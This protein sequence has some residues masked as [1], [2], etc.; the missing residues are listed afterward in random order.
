MWETLQFPA[1]DDFGIG[2]F[3]NKEDNKEEYHDTNYLFWN[4]TDIMSRFVKYSNENS[5]QSFEF[6]NNSLMSNVQ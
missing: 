4:I 6:Y 2:F 1:I 3:F 5:C